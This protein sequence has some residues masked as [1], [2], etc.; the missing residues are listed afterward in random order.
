MSTFNHMSE[1]S[2]KSRSCK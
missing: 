1:D 2:L